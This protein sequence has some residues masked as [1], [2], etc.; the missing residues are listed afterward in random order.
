V[1]GLSQWSQAG[2]AVGFTELVLGDQE[3]LAGA[4]LHYG[5]QSGLAG[6]KS[7]SLNHLREAIARMSDRADDH[8]PKIPFRQQGLPSCDVPALAGDR[9][10]RGC[11]FL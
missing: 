7:R 3:Q 1:N 2:S 6:E 11:A 4:V 9:N 5:G 10:G 8:I